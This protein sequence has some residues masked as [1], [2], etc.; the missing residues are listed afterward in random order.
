[1]L[2]C[3]RCLVHFLC[4]YSLHAVAACA[5]VQS[6]NTEFSGRQ[7]N[8]RA[9][10]GVELGA[11]VSHQVQALIMQKTWKC[12]HLLK[13]PPADSSP[14]R[15]MRRAIWLLPASL[16]NAN[17]RAI[18]SSMVKNPFVC[19]WGVTTDNTFM[20]IQLC[21]CSWTCEQITP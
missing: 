20:H 19:I 17:C 6:V 21:L 15:Q 9:G 8:H 16:G 11:R 4:L 1:M 5:R 3:I 12:A 18:S 13:L 7:S 14:C 10:F 2:N